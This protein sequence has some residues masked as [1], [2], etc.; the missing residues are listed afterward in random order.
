M[1]SEQWI[2][3][4]ALLSADGNFIINCADD[5]HGPFGESNIK[6]DFFLLV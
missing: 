1:W 3:S 4:C 5:Y 2:K 6:R